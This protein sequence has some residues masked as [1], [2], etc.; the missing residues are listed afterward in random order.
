VTTRSSNCDEWH[1][2][3]WS[4][5][6]RWSVEEC[7]DNNERRVVLEFLRRLEANPLEVTGTS[8]GPGFPGRFFEFPEG[9][10]TAVTWLVVEEICVVTL[11]RIENIPL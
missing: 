6:E 2:L 4:E 9:S 7:R 5:W 3:G 1:F 10:T 11:L 8:L